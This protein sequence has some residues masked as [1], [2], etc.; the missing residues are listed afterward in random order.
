M[1]EL[2]SLSLS[3]GDNYGGRGMFVAITTGT[4]IDIVGG[5]DDIQ[6]AMDDVQYSDARREIAYSFAHDRMPKL[7]HVYLQCEDSPLATVNMV[8]FLKSLIRVRGG[9]GTNKLECIRARCVK[10]LL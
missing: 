7:K 5:D 10:F 1:P 4:G 3:F 6:F 2:D 8:S 9:S